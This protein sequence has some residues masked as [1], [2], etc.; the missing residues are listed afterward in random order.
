MTFYNES[1]QFGHVFSLDG[2]NKYFQVCEFLSEFHKHLMCLNF[3]KVS[4]FCLKVL[5]EC[6]LFYISGLVKYDPI[7]ASSYLPLP[8]KLR[9]KQG[10]LNIQNDDDELHPP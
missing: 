1:L 7:R 8:K 9:A 5:S 2:E 10:C 3:D 4:F 6:F